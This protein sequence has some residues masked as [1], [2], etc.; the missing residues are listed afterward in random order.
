G[1]LGTNDSARRARPPAVTPAEAGARTLA[2]YRRIVERWVVPDYEGKPR[3][4][5]VWTTPRGT[6]EVE[7]YA[8]DAP[9]AGDD[10][11]RLNTGDTPAVVGTAFT[12]FVP[13]YVDQQ[14][15]VASGRVLRDEVNRH[16]LTRGNLSWATA[17]L[18]TGTP[19]YTLGHTPQPHN[20]GDFTSLGRVVA[21]Q[22]V[23]DRIQLGDRITAAAMVRPR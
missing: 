14:R 10:Y 12:R 11:V 16:R 2:D 17:G 13:D 23:V 21:G 22:D 6:I 5:A 4:R 9:L 20:E 7:L 1:S 19:G 15:P 3:P 8:G 18:D